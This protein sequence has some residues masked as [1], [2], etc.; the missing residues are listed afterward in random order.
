ML[1][2]TSDAKNDSYF[3]GVD[4]GS[5]SVRAGL[6]NMR[7]Q[8]LHVSSV[9]IQTWNPKPNFYQQSSDD[10]W[11]ACCTAVQEA[12]REHA[13]DVRG[14][15]FAGTCS[16]VVLSPEGQPVS[17][18]PCSG[19]VRQNIIMWMDHRAESEAEQINTTGHHVLEY[20]GG[21]IS[22][23]MQL[24]KLLWLKKNLPSQC[25]TRAGSLCSLVCKW[26][27]QASLDK[28]IGWDEDFLRS[29]GLVDLLLD[30]FKKIGNDVKTPGS[31]LG[32]GLTKKA[33]EELGLR[34]GIPVGASAIDAHAG[35][36]GLLAAVPSSLSHSTNGL[37]HRLALICGSSTCLMALS[38]EPLFV[39]GVWGPYANAMVPGYWLS[40]GGQSATGM[41]LDHIIRSHP[42]HQHL[43][44]EN[45]E[46]QVYQRLEG[47]LGSCQLE[48]GLGSVSLLT[49]DL[50]IWPDFHGNRSPLADPSL[51]GMMSGLTLSSGKKELAR[52]Y[53]ATVQ[54]L[55]YSTRHVIETMNAAGH[56]I[57]EILVCGGLSESSLFCKMQA[58]ITGHPV[59]VPET[60]EAV[61]LGA[62]I[63]GACAAGTW[64]DVLTAMS[65]MGGSARIINPDSSEKRYHDKKYQVFHELLNAQLRFQEIMNS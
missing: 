59:L 24:P 52:L 4:V 14:M 21:K 3:V 35:G 38:K 33:A 44:S 43:L 13:S 51:K 5:G 10:I 20:V 60:R 34:P 26:T 48:E 19:D 16:L 31:Q 2:M 36:I 7:G 1:G 47:I 11:S 63:L 58:D 54:A 39:H 12:T 27:Y 9:P 65:H 56:E 32:A 64:S 17:V 55:G 40:E 41:L 42:A 37:P 45:G 23:E 61:L 29:I 30:D 28:N 15:G 46:S 25:W 18:C 6:F 49:R 62:A 57:Q 53:L 8:C 22:L 50:H